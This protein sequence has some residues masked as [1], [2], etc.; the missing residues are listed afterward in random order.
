MSCNIE[1]ADKRLLLHALDV[2]HLHTLL[3]TLMFSADG[4]LLR[5]VQIMVRCYC[6]IHER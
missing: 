5:L 2:F 1:E 6:G 3:H 4:T